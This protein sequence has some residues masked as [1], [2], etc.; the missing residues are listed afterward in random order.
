MLM[1]SAI[2]VW[3]SFSMLARIC[4]K[5]KIP[6]SSGGGGGWLIGF[7]AESTSTLNANSLCPVLPVGVGFLTFDAESKSAK[8]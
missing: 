2:F 3:D 6:V 4:L 8:I 7:D 1:K 5:P